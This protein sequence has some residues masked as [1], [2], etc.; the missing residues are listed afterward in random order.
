MMLHAVGVVS[1]RFVSA[2]PNIVFVT[3][4]T[5]FWGGDK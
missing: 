4:I 5:V 2:Y 1:T 3:Y